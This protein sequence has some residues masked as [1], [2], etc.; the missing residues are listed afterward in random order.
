MCGG[1]GSIVVV[2][3]HSNLVRTRGV[4]TNCRRGENY[5]TTRDRELLEKKEEGEEGV[6]EGEEEEVGVV[7]S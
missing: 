1:G 2:P 6:E 3:A 4:H 5:G 7:A